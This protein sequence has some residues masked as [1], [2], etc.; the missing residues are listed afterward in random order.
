MAIDLGLVAQFGLF[1]GAAYLLYR[2]GG[3]C[4]MPTRRSSNRDDAPTRV[5]GSEGDRR[6]ED[7]LHVLKVRLAKGEIDPAQYERLRKQMES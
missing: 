3:C 6:T 5:A 7:P 1:A 2:G 4:G